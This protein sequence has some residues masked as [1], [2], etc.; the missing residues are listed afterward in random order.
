MKGEKR[1]AKSCIPYYSY[2]R[3][4]NKLR[5]PRKGIKHISRTGRVYYAS[6][7]I[8]GSYHNAFSE[9]KEAVLKRDNYPCQ[10]CGQMSSALYVHHIDNNGHGMASKPNNI[11]SNLIA[12]CRPCHGKHHGNVLFR[13]KAIVAL[14]LQGY[15]FQEIG[16]MF[17]VSRQRI[18]QIYLKNT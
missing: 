9:I 4:S 3:K 16:N 11:L 14:H 8:K 2:Y 17:G 1:I 18:H 5:K 6:P 12:V 13:N 10:L 7:Y 15:T